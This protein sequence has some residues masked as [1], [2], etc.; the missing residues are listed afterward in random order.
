MHSPE[1]STD[2]LQTTAKYMRR[3]SNN[4]YEQVA[5]VGKRSMQILAERRKAFE[6]ELEELGV[7]EEGQDEAKT[8]SLNALR[9]EVAKRYQDMLPPIEQARREF[10]VGKLHFGYWKPLQP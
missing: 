8:A 6:Q 10:S 3:I 7:V 4:V 5:V 9:E 1:T 2:T